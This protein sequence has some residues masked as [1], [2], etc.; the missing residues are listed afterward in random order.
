M[1]RTWLIDGPSGSG[2]T[3]HAA[4]LGARLGHRV[5]HMD[6]L[7]PGWW[8]L[9]EGSRIVAEEVLRMKAPGYHRWD[10]ERDRP[11]EWVALPDGE[12]LI[13]EGVGAMTPAT[14]AAA[15]RRGAVRTV[16]VTA[17]EGLRRRRALARDPYYEPWWETWARQERAHFAAVAGLE[18]DERIDNGEDGGAGSV[19]GTGGTGG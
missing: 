2:K 19:G 9:A 18:P 1:I 4:A 11:G 7:Y 12:P 13:V 6:D 10:W 15:R 5:V 8:G 16:L 3:T 17:P 14:V